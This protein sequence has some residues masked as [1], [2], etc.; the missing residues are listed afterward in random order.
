MSQDTRV[1]RKHHPWVVFRR[2]P[3]CRVFKHPIVYPFNRKVNVIEP[4]VV[5]A[6]QG[7]RLIDVLQVLVFRQFGAAFHGLRR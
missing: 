6:S 3:L 5:L 1:K 7:V 2:V 4:C